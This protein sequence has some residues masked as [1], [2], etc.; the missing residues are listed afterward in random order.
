MSFTRE[1]RIKLHALYKKCNPT[2][3]G[4]QNQTEA[5]K[6][7]KETKEKFGSDKKAF[8]KKISEIIKSLDENATRKRS[9]SM[10]YFVKVS[11]NYLYQ[12]RIFKSKI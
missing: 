9:D 10:S 1:L 5:N 4:Q 8:K 3:S 7:W 2:K 12:S 6:L 11:T